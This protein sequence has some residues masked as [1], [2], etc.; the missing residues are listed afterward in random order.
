MVAIPV[1]KALKDEGK[2]ILK[3]YVPWKEMMGEVTGGDSTISRGFSQFKIFLQ[4]YQYMQ[5]TTPFE[6]LVT[7]RSREPD[8]TK[9]VTRF[10]CPI[11]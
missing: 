11:P 3:R 2:F 5:M 10:I 9:W 7:D 4:E 6:L 1:N 8:T